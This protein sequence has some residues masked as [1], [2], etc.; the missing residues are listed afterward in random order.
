M[1]QEVR[2][3]SFGVPYTTDFLDPSLI[4]LSCGSDSSIG[5]SPS[6]PSLTELALP[7]LNTHFHSSSLRDILLSSSPAIYLRKAIDKRPSLSRRKP[8]DIITD[9]QFTSPACSRD[10]DSLHSSCIAIPPHTLKP[11]PPLPSSPIE[12]ALDIDGLYIQYRD[13]EDKTEVHPKRRFVRLQKI[14]SAA[15]L[16][17]GMEALC[18]QSDSRVADALLSP[19]TKDVHSIGIFRGT[20]GQMMAAMENAGLIATPCNGDG[21]TGGQDNGIFARGA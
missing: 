2:V 1:F 14:I 4:C 10:I 21:F 8:R 16:A 17:A 6:L 12:S 20:Y 7:R 13:H 15:V 5:S 9:K 19:M 18:L 11:L 3:D